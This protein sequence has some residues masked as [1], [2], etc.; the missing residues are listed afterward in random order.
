MAITPFRRVLAANRGE[1]AVRIFRASTELGFRTVAIFSEEDRVHL[2]RYKADEAYLVG[3]GLE[4]VAAYL[5]EDEI[6]EL[7]KRHEVDAIHPGYGL[8]SERASFARKCRDAGMT[9]VGPTPEVIEALGDKVAARKIAEAAGVPIVPG[10]PQ[11]VKT[12]AEARAFAERVG[13][14]VIIKASGGGGGRGMRVVRAAGELDELLTRARSEAKKAFGDDTVFLEKLVI[15]PKH[16]EVQILGDN[17]GNIVHLFERD[18]SVQRRHQKVIEYAPAWS[19][20]PALRARIADDALKIARHVKYSNAGTVEFLVGEDGAHYFIEVNP[21]IQVEHTVTEAITARDL[22]QAQIRIAQGYKLSDPEIGIAS[23][24]DI[25]QRGVAIQVRITAEDPRNDFMP[26]TGKI[27][28]YRPAVGNGIRLDDGSGYVGARV[29]QYYDSLLVK[30]TASGLE[31]NYVRRKA[32]RALREFRIRGV[33]TNLAFLENVLAHPTFAAGKAH[34]TFIDETPELMQMAARRDRATRILRYVGSTI[35]NGHPTVRG[36]PQA[37]AV[38]AVG[39]V[40]AAARAAAAAAA[41]HQAGAREGRTGRHREDAAQGSARL[42]HRHHLARRAPVAAGDAAAHLRHRARR[43]RDRAPLREP[44]L[45]GDVGRRDVRRRLPLPVGG[46]VGPAGG[47]AP[48]GPERDVPDAG[49][50]RERRRATPTT[51]TTS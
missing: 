32:I 10:T 39:G 28:V 45:A 44:V 43:A 38:G 5:A 4:P 19:L 49:A 47:A 51:P 14:P 24:A 11:G 18:C 40:G 36:K 20:P 21:R 46:S 12:V 25:Q 30:I 1:I 33:K 23:Q 17:H 9:F 13:Y 34:T 6:V 8:L 22:V 15:R 37:A 42:V 31:W 7:A 35:V 29:S 41:R 26:D 2:H 50:R 48:A 16:I 3:K 27:T